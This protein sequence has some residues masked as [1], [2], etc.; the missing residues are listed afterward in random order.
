MVLAAP[1]PASYVRQ[2]RWD[3]AWASTEAG[4]ADAADAMSEVSAKKRLV[5]RPTLDAALLGG[6]AG[7]LPDPDRRGVTVLERRAAD[8]DGAIHSAPGARADDA[9]N[10]VES[11]SRR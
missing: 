8:A 6:G 9:D 5:E 11:R 2:R 1:G 7:G 4:A 3:R 10:A